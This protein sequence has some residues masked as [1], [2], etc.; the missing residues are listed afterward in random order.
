M[1]HILLVKPYLKT[2]KTKSPFIE[3]GERA[4]EL[5]ELVHI[6]FVSP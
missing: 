4:F 1:N 6:I 3:I 2:I 5:F